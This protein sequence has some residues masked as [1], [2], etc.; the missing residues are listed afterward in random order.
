MDKY[1][2][3]KDCLKELNKYKY[4][5]PI[6]LGKDSNNDIHIKDLKDLKNILICGSTRSGKSVFLNSVINTILLTK[7]PQEVKLI[8][9][10]TKLGE[11]DIYKDI[12]HLMF[13]V[14]NDSRKAV[15]TLKDLIDN[16]I[17]KRRRIL[18]HDTGM[19]SIEEYN[20]VNERQLPR[21]VIVI[22]E[23]SDIM[24]EYSGKDTLTSVLSYCE[25]IG[26][27]LLLS[28]SICSERVITEDLMQ[29]IDTKL[30]GV[31]S[32]KESK[33][34]LGSTQASTLKGNG[35]M[36]Y[37]NGD[38][39]HRVQ[40]PYISTNEIKRNV[41]EAIKKYPDV[42]EEYILKE[43]YFKWLTYEQLCD[44]F[45]SADIVKV[46]GIEVYPLFFYEKNSGVHLFASLVLGI[47]MSYDS[48]IYEIDEL[49]GK[50]GINVKDQEK[51]YFKF[52]KKQFKIKENSL[53][54][55]YI[56]AELQALRD[57]T[58]I[59]FVISLYRNSV[60][61]L[62]RSVIIQDY[63][64][65][66]IEYLYEYPQERSKEIYIKLQELF[67]KI[68]KEEVADFRWGQLV[69]TN[70]CL[71]DLLGEDKTKAPYLEDIID[72]SELK[73]MKERTGFEVL[74]GEEY[75]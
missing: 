57:D 35:E 54:E 38:E 26:I 62:S 27:N 30:I 32:K 65:A 24:H 7:T 40:T 2:S 36:I 53:L 58:E 33:Y 64:F 69:F 41:K 66:E 52:L 15:S 29:K 61:F 1:I 8:L 31:Y 34:V 9:I 14:I 72:E 12:P 43:S 48:P 74:F 60:K 44:F 45:P 39:I 51:Y 13:P 49:E 70:Y 46:E 16:T 42:E 37:K 22:D 63:I 47:I 18:R 73:A 17:F 67:K 3:L 50:Y 59:D 11:F 5:L 28:T 10:D 21:I 20:S 23:F 19:D 56:R 4:S 25:Y 6:I 75:I 68:K 55:E 71:T